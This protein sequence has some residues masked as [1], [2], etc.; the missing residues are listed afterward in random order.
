MAGLYRHFRTQTTP[1]PE[2]TGPGNNFPEPPYRLLVD[3]ITMARSRNARTWTTIDPKTLQPDAREAYEKLQQANDAQK[4]ARKNLE[5]AVSDTAELPSTHRFVFSYQTGYL[6]V[7]IESFKRKQAK[8]KPVHFDKLKA[9]IQR[10]G[11]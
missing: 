6:S 10:G 3:G 7:A 2:L 9:D 4:A 8:S 11:S 1:P 5:R